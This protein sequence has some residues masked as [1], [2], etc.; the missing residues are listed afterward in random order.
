MSSI[1]NLEERIQN[2]KKQPAAKKKNEKGKE[3]KKTASQGSYKKRTKSSK[4][5]II[6]CEDKQLY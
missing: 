4:S 6:L 5:W 3:R 1:A 2:I